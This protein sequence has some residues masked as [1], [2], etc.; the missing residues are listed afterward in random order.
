MVFAILYSNFGK[1]SDK[2]MVCLLFNINDNQVVANSM[3]I[4]DIEMH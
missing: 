1:I 3:F 4:G 2:E